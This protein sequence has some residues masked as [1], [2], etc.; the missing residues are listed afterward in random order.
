MPA[1]LRAHLRYPDDLY[2][3]QTA[4]YATYHMD[5][6]IDFYQRE[7]QWQIPMEPG[8][9]QE[10]PFMRHIIMRL[11]D[12]QKAEFIYMVPFTPRGKQNL[13]AW[14]VAR[15]DGDN[16]G[17]LRVYKL[18]RQSLVFGPTQIENRINQNTQISQQVSLWDQHGS[19][20]VRG[21]LLVIPI[22]AALLYVQPL[23][24]Q[25]DQGRIPE[26][27]RVIVA[28]QD[29]VVMGQT[30]DDALTTLFGGA[31]NSSGANAAPVSAPGAPSTTTNST[32]AALRN[33]IDQARQHYDAAL[34]AQR[35]GDWARYGNE[36][37]ALGEILQQLGPTN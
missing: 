3:L 33:L 32:T 20:V 18:S 17:K 7:D 11:P 31:V 6:P 30:L 25:A 27:K 16:Y 29:Q 15:N 19:R 23:Y 22:N 10:V 1:D 13:A 12:E 37:K 35:N 28:Y 14:M 9:N 24:L 36:I 4:L 5:S 34:D 26:L 21:D 2:R 8:P